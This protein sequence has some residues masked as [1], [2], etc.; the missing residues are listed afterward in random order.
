MKVL[1]S[2]IIYNHESWTIDF[3]QVDIQDR[4]HHDQKVTL[5]C[6]GIGCH[7]CFSFM[8]MEWN[9]IIFNIV[10]NIEYFPSFLTILLF[11]VFIPFF[12][13]LYIFTSPSSTVVGIHLI[14]NFQHY[15]LKF[16][17]FFPS[18]GC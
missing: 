12:V 7:C 13:S 11:L 16:K 15:N 5:Y 9:F 14:H 10:N 3:T 17:S 8:I 18:F 2:L 4:I 1:I 6:C